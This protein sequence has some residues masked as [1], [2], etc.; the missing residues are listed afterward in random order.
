[1]NIREDSKKIIDYVLPEV[2]KRGRLSGYLPIRKSD[3]IKN[4]GLPSINYLDICLDYLYDKGLV[5]TCKPDKEIDD[6]N[7]T[8][9][10]TISAA[11]IDF[12]EAP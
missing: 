7:D 9:Q 1:M 5:N 3:L 10:I 12:L 6:N 8:F 2:I 11:A 4:C